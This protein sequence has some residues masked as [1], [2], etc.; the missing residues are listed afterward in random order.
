MSMPVN[1]NFLI[2]PECENDH[3]NIG[4]GQ[5]SHNVRVDLILSTI[6]TILVSEGKWKHHYVT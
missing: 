3:Y 4:N 2:Q 1:F 5:E 6:G